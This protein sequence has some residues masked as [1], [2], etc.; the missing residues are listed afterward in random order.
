MNKIFTL[1]NLFVSIVFLSASFTS[2]TYAAIV[3]NEVYGAGGN[4]GAT[5]N[6][7]YVELY[8]NGATSV[9]ISGYSL[10]YN[11]ATSAGVYTVCTITAADTLIEPNT[12]FLIQLG[13]QNAGVGNPIPTADSIPVCNTNISATAGKL[14][15]VNSTTQLIDNACPPTGATIVDFVGYGAT[16]NCSET[17]PAPA[18]ANNQSSIRRTTTGVDTNNNS[19]DFTSGVPTPQ[20][21]GSTAA[22]ATASGRVTLPNGRGIF[23]ALVTMTDSQGNARTAYTNQQ[24]YFNFTDVPGGENYIFTASHRRYQFAVSSQV[25]FIAEDNPGINFTATDGNGFFSPVF[26]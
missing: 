24:G 3:I 10:Q 23:R 8:N 22:G 18:P 15:L 20:A 26:P 21:S 1:R 7:D 11:P 25:Q 14:A 17:A 5:Y 9:D 19:V 16:A 4:T 2:Q 13:T 12:Y 6:R